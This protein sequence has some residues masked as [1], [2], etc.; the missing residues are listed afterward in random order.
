MYKS[1][2]IYVSPMSYRAHRRAI[3]ICVGGKRK[4]YDRAQT[5]RLNQR[6][7]TLLICRGMICGVMLRYVMLW[8]VM[9][10]W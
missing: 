2:R 10:S 8:Y 7:R 6:S 1:I 3:R 5:T 9:L 4:R